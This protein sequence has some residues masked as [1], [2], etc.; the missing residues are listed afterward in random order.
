MEKHVTGNYSSFTFVPMHSEETKLTTVT[1]RT[2]KAEKVVEVQQK[3]TEAY[4]NLKMAT[5][6]CT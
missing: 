2:L 6:R 1:A 5:A 3:R 4:C